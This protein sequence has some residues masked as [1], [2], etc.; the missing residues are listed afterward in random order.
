MLVAVNLI[1]FLRFTKTQYWLR[2]YIIIN[3][4]NICV[5]MVNDI[6]LGIPHE[7][8]GAE[9]IYR[10]CCHFVHPPDPAEAA[11]APVMHYIK[12]D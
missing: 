10:Q 8:I 4:V 3:S 11:V 5:G 9:E 1:E 2:V 6:V 7:V 12:S